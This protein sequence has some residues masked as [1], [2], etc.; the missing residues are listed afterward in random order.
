MPGLELD[1]DLTCR[2]V[3]LVPGTNELV[4]A[5]ERPADAC[6]SDHNQDREHETY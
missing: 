3:N 6:I 4:I 5:T 2:V 1:M